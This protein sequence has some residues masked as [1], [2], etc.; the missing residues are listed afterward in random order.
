VKDRSLARLFVA[1]DLPALV[2]E[3]LAAWARSA[4]AGAFAGHTSMP[5]LIPP[6]SMHL[7]LCFLGNRPTSEITPLGGAVSACGRAVGELS[8][9]APL[10]L[11]PRRP[12]ALAVE[13]R[14]ESGALRALKGDVL[15]ALAAV[16]EADLAAERRR[17]RPHVTVARLRE[18]TRP[19][20]RRLAPTP[21]LAFAPESLAL[22]RSFL[23][24]DGARYESLASVALDAGS[25]AG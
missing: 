22:Y 13:V 24:R 17:F 18:R 20:E 1:V 15:S 14:D 7:T 3:R 8:L 5:R 25:T 12:R 19:Q 4:V 16:S 23:A 2:R 11:P 6:E 21:A 9:G 10:W